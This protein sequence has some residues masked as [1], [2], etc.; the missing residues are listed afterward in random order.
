MQVI[1]KILI[2]KAD[3]LNNHK[4]I[5]EN[6]KKKIYIYLTSVAC[7]WNFFVKPCAT[8]SKL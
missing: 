7:E 1:N 3:K 5:Q 8:N 4:L 2:K 6:H